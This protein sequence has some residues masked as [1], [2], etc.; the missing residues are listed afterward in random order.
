M[1]LSAIVLIV[2]VMFIL[3]LLGFPMMVTM[4]VGS[5]IAFLF[6]LP[7]LSMNTVMSQMLLGIS[8]I[9]LISVPLFLFAAELMCRGQSATRLVDFVRAWVGHLPGGLAISTAL[10]CTLFGALSGSAQATVVAIGKPIRPVMLEASYSQSFT[11]GIIVSAAGIAL[12]I[13]P[14]IDAIVYGVAAK[15]SIGD[16]FLAGIGSG[17][18]VFFLFSIYSIVY[19][20]VKGIGTYPRANWSKRKIATRRALL[21]FGF[22]VI[23]IGGIFTGTFSPTEA[24]AVSVAYALVVEAGIY[25]GVDIK[26]F[27]ECAVSA[28]MVTA[29]IF[30]LVGFGQVFSFV[31][32]YAR[33]PQTVL[34]LLL[35]P[36][37]SVL[38]LILIIMA[39]YFVLCMLVAD[40]VVIFVLTPIFAPYVTQLGIDP[41]W[42]GA[43]VILQTSIGVTSP[44][45][46]VTIFTATAIFKRPFWEVTKGVPPLLVLMRLFSFCLP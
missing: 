42:L 22:P 5:L 45:F 24:A 13:P 46:G 14:S 34:P 38:R 44:P 33:V 29:I 4:A 40:I 30:I 16:L 7:G 10:G 11:S 26:G 31:L 3:L 15:T 9:A 28:G 23:I 37:P 17:L 2:A 27:A 19:S 20:K 18:V 41:I 1:S 8:P 35:G 43:M 12:L 25:R 6:Y 36:S 21:T 39:S 32:S